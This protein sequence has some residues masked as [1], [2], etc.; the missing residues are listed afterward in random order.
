MTQDPSQLFALRWQALKPWL[1]VILAFW[2]LGSLGL[3]WLVKSFV[4]LIGLMTVAPI[5]AFVG[6]RWWLG[7]NLVQATCPACQSNLTV[8]NQAQIQ[9]PSCGERLTVENRQLKRASTPGT[10]DVEAVEVV[11][12]VVEEEP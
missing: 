3:G 1:T 9:C 8:L 7:R 6:F 4:F 5:I 2:L 11:A 12:Q 10:I